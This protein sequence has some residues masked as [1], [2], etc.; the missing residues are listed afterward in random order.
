M[1]SAARPPRTRAKT[2]NH[3]VLRVDA[4]TNGK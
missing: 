2:Q 4:V 1:S 3:R